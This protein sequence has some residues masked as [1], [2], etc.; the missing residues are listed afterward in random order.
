MTTDNRAAHSRKK[1]PGRKHN[2][3]KRLWP[4]GTVMLRGV[5]M[6]P[7]WPGGKA[8]WAKLSHHASYDPDMARAAREMSR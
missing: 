7:T 1:G 8:Q 4:V 6:A 2:Q 3:S 5:T